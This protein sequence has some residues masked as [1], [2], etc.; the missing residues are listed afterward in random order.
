MIRQTLLAVSRS[1][2]IRQLSVSMPI[3]RDVVQQFVAGENIADAVAATADITATGRLVTIDRLGEDVVE[4]TQAQQTKDDY[5]GLLNVLN[6]NGLAADAEVSVKLSAV[7]QMLPKD[8]EKVALDLARTV[9]EKAQSLGSAVTLDME[10]HTTT[11]STL[12]ILH[13]LRKDF[14]TTGAV[15]QAY[16]YRTE[17]DCKDLAYEGSRIRLCKGAYSEPEAVAYQSKHDVD[18]AFVR[19]MKI[20]FAGEGYPMIASHDPR[21]VEIAGALAVH[22]DRQRGSYEYQMLY[23]VRPEEQQRLADDGERM[24]VYIPYGEDWYGYMIRRMAE[25]PANVSLFLKSL[26]SKN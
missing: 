4:L 17:G 22:N 18:L 14:P 25:K 21:L 12:G 13:E 2:K 24:R 5:L 11:D 7:G 8:G 1:D 23:G 9:C 10:D 20:L 16:L 15:L 6:A 26:S 19:C 3:T